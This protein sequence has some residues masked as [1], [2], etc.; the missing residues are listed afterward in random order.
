MNDTAEL[1]AASPDET[2]A[3]PESGDEEPNGVGLNTFTGVYRPT[4][5]TIL[6]V[7]MY[8]REGWLVGQ[9]G[10]GGAVLV[11][12]ATFTI[13]GCTAMS[14]STITTN[15]R[16]GGG[17]AFAVIS[18]SLGLEAGG[19]IG[20]PLYLAQSL[21][22]ALYMYGFAET[23]VYLF[24]HP[25]WAAILGVFA[26]TFTITLL[27]SKLASKLQGVVM[28]VVLASL[29][30]IALGLTELGPAEHLQN[31]QLWGDFESGSFWILFAIFF[32]AGTGIMVG[33]SMS[34]KLEDAR[35]SIPKGTLAA[36]ATSLVVYLFFALWYSLL[37]TPEAL[38]ENTLIV[39]ELAWSSEI[40]FAGILASTFT[41]TLSSMVA[42][43]NVLS[44]LGKY[45]VTPKGD[46]LSKMTSSGDARNATLVTGLLIAGAL[47][48]GSLNAVAQ[49]ITMFFLLTY[50]MVNLVVMVEQQLG[51]VSFRPL[52]KIPRL[53]PILGTVGCTIAVFVIS[54]AFGLVAIGLVAAVYVYLVGR[55]LEQPW[56]TVRSGMF[57]ALADW[58]A[59]R[60]AR[61]QES[62]ERSWKPDLLVPVESRAELDG[63]FR[64][65]RAMTYPKG[66]LHIVGI[67]ARGED[68]LLE[69]SDEELEEQTSSDE[70]KT[71]EFD[72][73]AGESTGLILP[74]PKKKDEEL[75][76]EIESNDDQQPKKKRRT[77]TLM[78]APPTSMSHRDENLY[79]SMTEIAQEFQ[80]EQLFATSAVIDADSTLDGVRASASIMAGSFFRPNI[81]YGKSSG[82]APREIQGLVDTAES[83]R[84]GV[85]LLHQHERAGLGHER[86]VNVWIRDQSPDWHLGLR[87]ANLDL[88]LLL[89]YQICRNWKGKIRF[90]TIC[91]DEDD[92]R[93]AEV[94]LHDL[95][96][97]ARLT[98]Y[99]ESWVRHGNFWETLD[100]APR[101]DLNIFGLAR[102]V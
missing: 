1:A 29:V 13:T 31:P 81:L 52:F 44:A 5:L 68:R 66:S 10:L 2:I 21:S 43:P 40:V 55:H 41:A 60:I 35:S 62:N 97:E 17:G 70:P 94:Y 74:R 89:A 58:A 38:R 54:P 99:G 47:S 27:S 32:P 102:D 48:L 84:M 8:L 80:R 79:A 37:A 11:I 87:L 26:V 49:L 92:V 67:K 63:Q 72:P 7:M 56:E 36:V 6:G 77:S 24:D 53:V 14:L 46:F 78:G 83:H 57:V 85:A 51:M 16:L 9:A 3:S 34:G 42:A 73:D 45:G 100:H 12:L 28:L 86:S 96:D 93:M 22:A 69:E 76:E 4:V 71:Q 98:P 95:I 23:W 82:L 88:S 39:T 30:S 25:M 65:L 20:I 15:I 50:F 91:E 59:K 64:F 33:A 19:S 75:V 101:A 18:Q 61:S 90:L